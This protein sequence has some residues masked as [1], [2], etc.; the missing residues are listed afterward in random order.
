M[1]HEKKLGKRL[2][3]SVMCAAMLTGTAAVQ[4]SAE[5]D[6]TASAADYNY[7][8]ALELS[9]YFFDA[10]QCGSEVDDNCLTWR[11]NCHTY[12]ETASLDS[13]QGLSGASKSAIMAQNGGSSTVDVSGGYHDTGDHIK[14][15]MTMGFSTA[16]L[17]WSYYTYPEAY[18]DSGCEDHLLYILRHACDYFMKV[19][20]LDDNDDVIAFCYQ[21]ASEGEDHSTWSAPESQTMN[22]TTYWADSSH[23]SADASGQMA[24]SLA[25][26]ALAFKDKDPAYSAECLKYANALAEFTKKYPQ[27]T[28][29]GVGSMYASG[30]QTDDIAWSEL[31]CAIANNGGTLPSSYTPTYKLTGQGCYNNDQYDG[32]MYSWDKVWSGYAAL[33]AEVG[34]EQNTY[35]EEMK[36]SLNKQG[37]LTTNKYNAAGW[38]ASRYNCALQMLALHIADITNDNSYVEAAKYQMDYILG[39][40]PLGYSFLSGYGTSWPTHIHHRAANPNKSSCTYTLYGGLIGG[41]DSSGNYSDD[42]EQYQF[43][44]PALDYNGCYALAIAGL[45]SRYGG[46]ASAA[47]AV[48]A[49]ASEIV[50]PFDFGSGNETTEPTT[51]PPTEETT[52]P[53]TETE[54][55]ET[56][57]TEPASDGVEITYGDVNC[58]GS[59]SIS[60]VL[61]LNKNLMCGEKLSQLGA[62]NADVDNDGSPTSADALNILK[63]VIKIISSLPV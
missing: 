48:A 61:T 46:D 22:R 55:T 21:V 52:L 40:N 47:D 35:L 39:N 38:G 9:L 42:T 16:S 3:A 29:D 2:L 15:S 37:G 20:Y 25:T 23:P 33:L 45:A 7:A 62:A 11:G 51:E 13:A 8:E 17:G 19:T 41:P 31:W 27:A 60:D 58:D 28:Y 36:S 18:I 49:A 24:A 34:Y 59:V 32:W 50:S 6:V 1:K 5:P 63:F 4:F 26:T 10:N 43:T 53:P 12:D 54:T 57:E 44:E 30:S 14:F 56:T